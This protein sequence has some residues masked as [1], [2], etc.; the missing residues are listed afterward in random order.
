MFKKRGLVILIVLILLGIFAALYMQ[1]NLYKGDN[2]RTWSS[3]ELRMGK[4]EIVKQ[5]ERLFLPLYTMLLAL[6]GY[7]GYSIFE[8]FVGVHSYYKTSRFLLMIATYAVAAVYLFKGY[9]VIALAQSITGKT[10]EYV[11]GFNK[12][13]GP[14]AVVILLMGI[15]YFIKK[16][17]LK[18]RENIS[19]DNERYNVLKAILN[20]KR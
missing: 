6:I 12:L 3:Y 8:L 16:R 17:N 1:L 4:G 5:K 7:V 9:Y 20:K 15:N 14:V 13:M 10:A 18:Q 11:I 19:I 2:L